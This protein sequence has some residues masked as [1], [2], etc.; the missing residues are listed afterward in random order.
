MSRIYQGLSKL[1]SKNKQKATQ[2]ENKH[3]TDIL[4]TDVKYH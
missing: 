1:I 2:L 3:V 4:L